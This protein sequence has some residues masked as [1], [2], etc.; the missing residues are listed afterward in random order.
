MTALLMPLAALTFYSALSGISSEYLESAWDLGAGQ[1][2]TLWR[3]T[4]PLSGR[5]VLATAALIFFLAA[6]D[7]ITPVLVGGLSTVTIGRVVSD[8]FSIGEYGMGAALSFAMLAGFV[9]V[10]MLTRR[11]MRSVG[12]LPEHAGG[13][14]S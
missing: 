5:A 9:V 8:E 6:G 2:Q 7:Y 13:P 14:R 10:Y 4:L 1:F 11:G 12:M 3:V